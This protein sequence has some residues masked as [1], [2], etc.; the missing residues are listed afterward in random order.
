MLFRWF[1][2]LSMDTQVWDVT[3]FTKNRG[4]LLAGDVA[5]SFLPAVMGH[6]AIKRLLPAEHF[7]VDG[8]LIDAWASTKSFRRKDGSDE[9]PPVGTPN[10]TCA[11]RS[12]AMRR[13]PRRPTP[14]P[15]SIARAMASHRGSASWVIC[16]ARTGMG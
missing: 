2:G 3:V 12:A 7:S 8:T 4:R 9:P 11:A 14:T 1:V 13:M 10:G 15:G 6:A 5:V 16:L